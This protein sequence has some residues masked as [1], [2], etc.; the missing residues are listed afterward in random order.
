MVVS[1]TWS[2]VEMA[3]WSSSLNSQLARLTTAFG[4]V[5]EGLKASRACWM[6][7]T[8]SEDQLGTARLVMFTCLP[9]A[10]EIGRSLS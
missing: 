9:P 2:S 5:S 1:A 10:S 8:V 4:S 6:D 3:S 7:W